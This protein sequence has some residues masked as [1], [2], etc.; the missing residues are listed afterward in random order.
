MNTGAHSIL[1]GCKFPKN[2]SFR[3]YV[4]PKSFNLRKEVSKGS[5]VVAG[6]LILLLARVRQE[7]SGE[8]RRCKQRDEFLLLFVFFWR[9]SSE[10]FR[11]NQRQTRVSVPVVKSC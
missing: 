3:V 6:P 2:D 7:H 8:K 10:V 9:S 1:L 5:S 11:V 4:I